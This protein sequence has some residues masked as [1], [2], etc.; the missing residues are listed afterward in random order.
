MGLDCF[1]RPDAAVKAMCKRKNS[2]ALVTPRD[3]TGHYVT[4]EFDVR[5]P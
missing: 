5:V 3:V 1:E 4:G 2:P